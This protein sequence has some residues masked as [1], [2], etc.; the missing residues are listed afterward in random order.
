MA[1]LAIVLAFGCGSRSPYV[2]NASDQCVLDGKPGVCEST[3]FCSFTDPSCPGG[4]KYDPNAGDGLGGKCITVD[5]PL[6]P[7][8]AVGQACCTS[9][10]E[11]CVANAYCN[12]STCATCATQVAFGRRFMC[13]VKHDGTV[14]C[15]GSNDQGQLGLGVASTMNSPTPMQVRDSN[16][17]LIA[18]ATAVGAGRE[19]ACAIRKNGTVWCWGINQSG[20]LGNN[21]AFPM[22]PNPPPVPS[23]FA[24]QVVQANG[25][26]ITGMVSV[27]ASRDHTCA[28]DNTGAVW[29]WGSNSSNSLGDGTTTN[30]STAAPVLAAAGGAAFTGAS[31]LQVSSYGASCV[32]VGADEWCWG[33][34]G[35]GEFGDGTRTN[36]PVPSKVVSTSSFSLG[37]SHACWVN[38]DSTVS[39]AGWGGHGRL[40]NGT[41]PSYDEGDVLM[42]VTVL[43]SLGGPPLTGIAKVAAGGFSCAIAVD[44]QAYCWGDDAYGQTGTGTGSTVPAQLVLRDGTPLIGIDAITAKWTHGCVHTVDG[45]LRCWGR[46]LEGEL[47]DGT[48]LNRGTPGELET[49]CQ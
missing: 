16:A 39:C 14:W 3:G 10:G 4:R 49:M 22:P 20:Q 6:P 40:G 24:V 13:M 5:A 1:A 7:C 47:G 27:D 30:R 43:Q 25:Q 48:Y 37:V 12:A 26:P 11:A 28:L 35:D 36:R 15:S 23:P 41:G 17:E 29:C 8:G 32:R 42:P 45:A 33:Y 18:D 31:E 38:A 44:G 21:V 46:N 2:C 34:N 19:H 9:E